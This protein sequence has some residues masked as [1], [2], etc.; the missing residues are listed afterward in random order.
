[1][2]P[3]KRID[4]AVTI[5][6][7]WRERTSEVVARLTAHGFEQTELLDAVGVVL[8]SAPAAAVAKLGAVKGVSSVEKNRT[9]YR[10]Q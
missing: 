6:E 9:D 5:D 7:A 2:S 10:T 8:G 1:M 3:T 4:V